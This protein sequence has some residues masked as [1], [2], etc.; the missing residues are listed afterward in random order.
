MF[1]NAA[2]QGSSN[3]VSAESS[4][5]MSL[6]NGQLGTPEAGPPAPSLERTA[7]RKARILYRLVK[8]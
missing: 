4:P 2:G 6:I 1:N 7:L 5:T 8:P 3:G